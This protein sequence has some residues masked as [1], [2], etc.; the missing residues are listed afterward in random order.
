M[1]TV[2]VIIMQYI[3]SHTKEQLCRDDSKDCI[4]SAPIHSKYFLDG[5]LLAKLLKNKL[6][7]SDLKIKYKY[8]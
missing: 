5:N 1:L 6:N 3:Q 4:D 2:F 7:N 8:Y